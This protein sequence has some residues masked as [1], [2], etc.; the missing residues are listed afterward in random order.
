[1][2]KRAH[3]GVHHKLCPKHLQRYVDECGARQNIG[4]LDMLDQLTVVSAWLVDKRLKYRELIQA[5]GLSSGA[6]E[7]AA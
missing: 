1:M 3:K 5:N 2:L 4:E 6:Q 7:T